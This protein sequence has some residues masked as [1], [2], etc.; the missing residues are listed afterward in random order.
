MTRSISLAR[1]D[2]WVELP[3]AASSVRSRQKCVER[4]GLGFLLT[5]GG[6]SG[7]GRG[8]GR[9][10]LRHIAAEEAKRLGP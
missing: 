4:R 8:P 9:R 10:S 6:G 5:L 1:A 2:A 7:A 3:S